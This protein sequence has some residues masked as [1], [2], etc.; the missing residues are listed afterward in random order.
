MEPLPAWRRRPPIRLSKAF[1]MAAIRGALQAMQ[2]AEPQTPTRQPMIRI[3]GAVVVEMAALEARE[4]SV[5]IVLALSVA[6]AVR[7]SRFLRARFLWE[8]APVQER[9]TTVPTGFPARIPATTIAE[10]TAPASIAA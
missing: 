1:P 7:H 3:A 5:G 9:Q 4:D 8:A 6:S 10:Q 2:A